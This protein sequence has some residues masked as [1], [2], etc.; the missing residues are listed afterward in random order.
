MSASG[1]KTLMDAAKVAIAAG[2]YAT[3]K[4]NL[5]QAKAEL[6]A[7]PDSSRSGASLTWDRDAIDSLL[8]D[9]ESSLNATKHT[10]GLQRQKLRYKRVSP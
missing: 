9:V 10:G 5:L 4:T 1:L 8:D 2:D 6:I 3:A 7:M